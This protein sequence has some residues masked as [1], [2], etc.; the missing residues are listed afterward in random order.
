M[1]LLEGFLQLVEKGEK[2]KAPGKIELLVLKMRGAICK[3]QRKVFCYW[4]QPREQPAS[5]LGLSSIETENWNQ[6]E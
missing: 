4:Q 5:K 2:L 3:D 1:S 6:P